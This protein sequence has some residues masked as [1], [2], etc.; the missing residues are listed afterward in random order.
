MTNRKGTRPIGSIST[1]LHDDDVSALSMAGASVIAYRAQMTQQ[2][3][4]QV[5][6]DATIQEDGEHDVSQE[7]RQHLRD[8]TMGR[9]RSDEP[10]KSSSN[11]R[12][13]VPTLTSYNPHENTE[14]LNFADD[15]QLLERNKSKKKKKKH[16]SKKHH[17]KAR[18][19]DCIDIS[20]YEMSLP[21][22]EISFPTID[23]PST[24]EG[25]H[26]SVSHTRPPTGKGSQCNPSVA[27]TADSTGSRYQRGESLQNFSA[28]FVFATFQPDLP[29]IP[30]SNS[31]RSSFASHCSNPDNL[32]SPSNNK[33]SSLRS[34]RSICSID[35]LAHKSLPSKD[36]LAQSSHISGHDSNAL[37]SY[38]SIRSNASISHVTQ[39]DIEHIK[40]EL[41]AAKAEE[42]KVLDLHSKLEAEILKLIEKA[43]VIE[44]RRAKVASESKLAS[45]ERKRLQ[46]LLSDTLNENIRMSEELQSLE[47]QEDE[48][49]LDD[50]LD[51]MQAKMKLLRLKSLK[52]GKGAE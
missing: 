50:V 11:R 43:E 19:K 41:K 37:K 14:E 26:D 9:Y 16:K 31:T 24:A 51:G 13:S 2:L 44:E 12:R 27:S 17:N 7:E 21:I 28:E 46:S 48:K 52:K 35:S 23:G 40:N 39:D 49:R 42:M 34:S 30:Q 33:R 15:H 5:K 8:D 38:L 6:I 22:N 47:E 29:D 18:N 3:N 36:S 20:E 32:K 25:S 10:K 45:D 4:H 1:S